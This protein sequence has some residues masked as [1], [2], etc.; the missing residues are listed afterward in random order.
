MSVSP[1]KLIIYYFPSSGSINPYVLLQKSALKAIGDVVDSNEIFSLKLSGK[2]ADRRLV[3]NWAESRFIKSNNRISFGMLFRII[4][5]IVVGRL[6]CGQLIWVKHNYKPHS[7]GWISG[8]FSRIMVMVLSILSNKICVHD[9][10]CA[11]KNRWFYIPHPLYVKD[12]KT[13][14]NQYSAMSLNFLFLGRVMPYKKLER[15]L[16]LWPQ[17]SPLVIAGGCDDESYGNFLKNIAE[18]RR[19]S[20]NFDLGYVSETD[21]ESYMKSCDVFILPHEDGS[22]IVSGG[23]YLAKSYGCVII[24]STKLGDEG[25]IGQFYFSDFNLYA[26][27]ESALKF[28]RSHSKHDVYEDILTDHSEKVIKEFWG[29]CLL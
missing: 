25:K 3:M 14:D 26:A 18:K 6:R 7:G 21:L 20:V 22:A 12:S 10:E 4:A 16:E 13:E 27:I 24:S 15:I 17:D 8:I 23:Y 11:I 9:K 19:L 29:R 2:R 5:M 28:C 1:K